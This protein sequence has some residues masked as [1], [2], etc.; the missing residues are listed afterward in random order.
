MSRCDTLYCTRMMP[1]YMHLYVH[2]WCI[3]S[4]YYHIPSLCID[5]SMH[6]SAGKLALSLC[7]D[8]HPQ[9]TLVAYCKPLLAGDKRQRGGRQHTTSSI[10]CRWSR[11]SGSSS[12]SISVQR[13]PTTLRSEVTRVP[14]L[15]A[16]RPV[17]SRQ[18]SLSWTLNNTVG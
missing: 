5:K 6:L 2:D 11:D 3:K 12:S 8:T 14:I 1:L 16:Y 18:S 13:R 9:N 17:W 10:S 4:R 7:S 15:Q